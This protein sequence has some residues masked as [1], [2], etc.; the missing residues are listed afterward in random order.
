MGKW[1]PRVT[2]ESALRYAIFL[3]DVNKL[4]DAALVGSEGAWC[5][6]SECLATA[7][8][9]RLGPVHAGGATQP[10]GPPRLLPLP[11]VFPQT[12]MLHCCCRTV[13]MRRCAAVQAS[14]PY[15]QRYSVDAHLQRWDRWGMLL[16]CRAVA[17]C[18]ARLCRTRCGGTALQ[19]GA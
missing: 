7:G 11:P 5:G 19:R 4:F 10:E 9:V 8:H 13:L 16:C 15:Y 3:T 14:R 17:C 1:E 6:M 2:C 18:A 12:G